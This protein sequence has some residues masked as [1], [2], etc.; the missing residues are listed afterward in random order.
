MAG[1]LAVSS[2]GWVGE[3]NSVA[4]DPAELI[5]A[6]SGTQRQLPSDDYGPSV[7]GDGNV[8]VFNSF[9]FNDGTLF[10]DVY[11][12][13]RANGTTTHVPVTIPPSSRTS[14]GVVSRDGCHVVFWGLYY[15]DFPAGEWILFS[16]DRCANTAPVNIA[17]PN[18]SPSVNPVRAAV[19]ADGRY[20][21]YMAAPSN[22]SPPRIARIDT[23]SGLESV[24]TT[25]FVSASSLDISDDGVFIA[26]AGQRNVAGANVNQI[27]GWSA[28]CTTSCT[29]EVVSVNSL[30]QPASGTSNCPTVSADGRYVAFSSNAPELAGLPA[31][32]PRQVYVRDRGA[33][34][35]RLVTDTP[36]QPMPAG[37]GV[38]SPEITPDGSQI[39]LTQTASNEN[40]QVWVARST[41]GYF[42]AVAFDLVSFGVSG[43]EVSNGA[44]SPSMSS[45]GRFV[46][47][48]SSSNTELS[49]GSVP[50]GSS[51][52]WMRE[53]PVA[54]DITPTLNFG[55]V[56]VGTQSAP[57]NAVVTNTSGVSINIG[58]VTSPAAPFSIIANGCGGV[59][60][61]GASCA[62]TV[63]FTPTSGGPASSSIT[64]SGDGL[65]VSVSLLGTGRS[66]GALAINPT[67]ADY[68]TAPIGA[69]LA[70]RNFVVTS[71]GTAAV[72][73]VAVT[74]SGTG[75]DQ[76]AIGT[77][78]CTGTLAP[79]A[80]CTVAVS[81]TVT[82]QGSLS[83]TLSVRGT[84]GESAQASLRV[85]GDLELFTP[86]LKMN[87]GV[88]G[89]GEITAAIGSDFPPNI[90]V[91][92][93]FA[94][95]DPFTTVHTDADGAF[96][97][98][99]L[100]LRNGIRIGG[101]EVIAVD[102]PQ[103]SGVR[104]PLLID[105]ATF[106]PSGFAS[107]AFGGVRSLYRGG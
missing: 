78:T 55:T 77:N 83:A 61:P 90:D 42:D 89:P 43:A 91:Q 7:S 103:F 104:A 92:L 95:E 3:G 99:L 84:G 53:R 79:G 47:F 15:F 37:L 85:R 24:L 1:L 17:E 88:V 6:V 62:V 21:A 40:T 48:D 58:G 57:Q 93:A 52:V 81:A 65:S 31:G 80:T 18:L 97:F 59:L 12:R 86:T 56:D 98:N 102:Q 14:D 25:P 4:A 19:S 23:S 87:P 20:V 101:R 51:E 8:V 69:S 75:A 5:S 10:E 82:R 46:A 105:L 36:G 49:G 96:R 71:T 100:V 66:S 33:G 32:T 22:T 60:A 68:G 73:L 64:V 16:W 35:T 11:V 63:V 72:A 67:S 70:A 39:A 34:I 27:V 50:I 28:P 74:L 76:F 9:D 26:I 13:N 106:R 44:S 54:L 94:G 45:T 38:G 107:P 30:E 2:V 41:A 29:T